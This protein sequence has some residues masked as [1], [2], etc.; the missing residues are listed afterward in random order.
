MEVHRIFHVAVCTQTHETNPEIQA[1]AIWEIACIFN[2]F[3]SN[4]NNVFNVK[5]IDWYRHFVYALC[6]LCNA[7]RCK[8]ARSG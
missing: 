3:A 6:A 8:W 1:F 5:V 7:H 2:D 4:R